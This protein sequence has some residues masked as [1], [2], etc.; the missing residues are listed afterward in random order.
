MA[1]RFCPAILDTQLEIS[2][3]VRYCILSPEHEGPHEGFDGF[4]W[5]SENGARRP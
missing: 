2:R 4:T 5:E 3:R 1:L